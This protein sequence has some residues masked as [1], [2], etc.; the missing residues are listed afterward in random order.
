MV[1]ALKQAYTPD[2]PLEDRDE[3]KLFDPKLLKG[4]IEAFQV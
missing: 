1:E 4:A 3:L 2:M